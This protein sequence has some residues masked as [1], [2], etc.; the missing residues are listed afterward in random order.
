MNKKSSLKRKIIIALCV[1]GGICLLIGSFF[2]RDLL[3]RAGFVEYDGREIIQVRNK[4]SAS[5]DAIVEESKKND[6]RIEAKHGGLFQKSEITTDE[7]GKL[8][9]EKLKSHIDVLCHSY[10]YLISAK[11]EEIVLSFNEK[12]TKTLIYK[13]T[14]PVKQDENVILSDLGGNWYYVDI[15]NVQEPTENE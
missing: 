2:L 5:L 11:N 14:E 8:V 10:C 1:I 6:F 13:E 7:N 9:Y 4:Y 15:T 12:C 3:L